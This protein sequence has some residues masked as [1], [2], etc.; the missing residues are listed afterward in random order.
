MEQT[1]T[2]TKEKR[3]RKILMWVIIVN[4]ILWPTAIYLI[5]SSSE[6]EPL[7][8]EKSAYYAAREV[9]SNHLKSPETAEYQPYSDDIVQINGNTY[10]INLYVD[11]ENAFGALLRTHFIVDVELRDGA[12]YYTG[13]QEY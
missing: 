1:V 7:T 6:P 12:W 13:I 2:Q 10:S 4:V 9:V 3:K 5:L 11:A 8:P